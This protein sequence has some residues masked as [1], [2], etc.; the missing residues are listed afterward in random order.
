MEPTKQS[1]KTMKYTKA[2]IEEQTALL[3]NW[4]PEGSTVYTVLRHV[5][6]SGMSREVGVVAIVDKADIRHPNHAVSVVLG[7]A[8][9]KGAKGDGVKVKGCGMDMGFHLAYALSDVLYGN[10]YALN[11]RWI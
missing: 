6:A 4:F 5:S 8:R 7:W 3:K 1:E 10:G 9:A 11:H 2:E